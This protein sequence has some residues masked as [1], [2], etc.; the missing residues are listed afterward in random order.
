MTRPLLP[1]ALLALVLAAAP[2]LGSGQNLQ[3]TPTVSLSQMHDDNLFA[4]PAAESDDISRLGAGLAV[5]QRSARLTVKARYALEAETFRRHPELNRAAARQDAA[6]GVEWAAS[7]RLDIALTA[8]YVDTQTPSELNALTGLEIGRRRGRRLST[9]ALFTHRLGPRSTSRLEH[10]FNRDRVAGLTGN[11]AHV[12]ALGLD[13][14][15]GL[16]DRGSV[17][18]RAQRV[19]FGHDVTLSHTVTLGWSRA[20]SRSSQL[21]LE[22]GPRW[23]GGRLGA[24]ASAQLR[25][26]LRHGHAAIDYTRSQTTVLGQAGPVTVEGVRAAFSHR[27]VGPLWFS[28]SPG[29]FRVVGSGS[30]QSTLFGVSSEVGWRMARSVTLSGTHQF[31]RQEGGLVQGTASELT[32]NTFALALTRR[33]TRE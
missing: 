12:V 21:A 3:V 4:T 22:A 25:R 20:M 18:Y 29:V 24:E 32:H 15:L 23:T 30:E 10:R 1:R 6:L 8:D 19:A 27:L 2:R 14:R 17:G 16:S 7:Q 31:G 11:D 13:R 5:G 26:Q 9:G 28:A 33:S